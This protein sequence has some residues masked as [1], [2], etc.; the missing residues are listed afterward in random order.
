MEIEK[1]E[2][3]PKRLLNIKEV[4]YSLGVCEKTV[5][6]LVK[7]GHLHPNKSLGKLLFRLEDMEA[8]VRGE[9]PSR[10]IK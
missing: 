9:P 2:I 7:R 6:N 5:R 8:F 4:A 1:S 10:N 3:V